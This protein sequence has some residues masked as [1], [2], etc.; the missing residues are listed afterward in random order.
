M[1]GWLLQFKAVLRYAPA[2]WAIVQCIDVRQLI[3]GIQSYDS[4]I[5]EAQRCQEMWQ[6]QSLSLLLFRAPISPTFAL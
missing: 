2:G 1:A 3:L 5:L 6:A 4:N